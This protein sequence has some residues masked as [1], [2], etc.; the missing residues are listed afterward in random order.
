MLDPYRHHP[1]IYGALWT[2]NVSFALIRFVIE[3]VWFII[4]VAFQCYLERLLN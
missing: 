4:H 2:T 1:D 3:K